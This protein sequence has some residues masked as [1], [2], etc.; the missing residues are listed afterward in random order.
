MANTESEYVIVDPKY[1]HLHVCACGKIFDWHAEK[2][3]AAIQ[4]AKVEL[5]EELKEALWDVKTVPNYA[6]YIDT[7]LSKL[8]EK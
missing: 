6:R 4:A 8:R 5:L 3:E 7:E 2:T 1:A